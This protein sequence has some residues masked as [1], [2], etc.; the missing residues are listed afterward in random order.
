[1]TSHG[2]QLSLDQLNLGE[3]EIAPLLHLLDLRGVQQRGH[4]EQLFPI[5]V[6]DLEYRDHQLSELR[7]LSLQSTALQQMHF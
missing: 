1:M 2:F 3:V 6:H 4:Q 5:Q 7:I